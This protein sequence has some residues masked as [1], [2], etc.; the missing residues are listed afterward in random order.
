MAELAFETFRAALETTRGTAIATPTHLLN[1]ESKLTPNVTR[2]RPTEQR[3]S[4]ALN[5][6]SLDTQK[7]SAWESKGD[8]D[9][10]L[11]PFLLN[12]AVAPVSSGSTPG[13]AA[14]AKLW[15]FVRNVL[16]DDIKSA[17]VWWGDPALNQLTTDFVM[18]DELV[19]E[20]D[21]SGDSAATLEA[22]GMGGFPSKVAAPVATTAVAGATLPGQLIQCWI[23]T[24]SAIGTTAVTGRV[25][26]AKH[27]I[28]TGVAYKYVA[29]G[30][31][32]AAVPSSLDYTLVGREKIAACTTELKIELIDFT[33]Y[34]L[35]A[36][37]TS[38]KVRVR[39]NGAFIETA[40]TIDYFNYLEVDTYGPA[41]ALDWDDNAGT[42]RALN[43]TIDATYDA[44]L[45]SDLRVAVQNTSAT[46]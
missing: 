6:R 3:G 33:Q 1:F 15:A 28:R 25:V 29:T 13:T 18:L 2:Y 44:T 45:A 12:M 38:L 42:N 27:T 21:A 43:L 17:T 10:R 7:N 23:D 20:N 39:H 22:K 35:W 4:L 24:S 19:I 41:V 30:P 5:Y 26:K 14:T 16:A 32:T 46:L 31:G 9:V 37:G 36:A 11:L 8:A 40:S 34:D